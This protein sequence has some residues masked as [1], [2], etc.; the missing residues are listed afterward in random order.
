[1]AHRVAVVAGGSKGIGWA[2]S[3][4][5]FGAGYRVH[6]LSR[7]PPPSLIPHLPDKPAILHFPCDIT[8]SQTVSD[9]LST[10]PTPSVFVYSAGVLGHDSLLVSPSSTSHI[11]LVF[12]TNTLACIHTTRSVVRQMI[13]HKTPQASV[14]LIGS[15]VGIDG[16]Q[17]QCIYSASKSALVGFTKSLAK[18][19]GSRSI[20]VNM[21]A[22][23]F[24]ETD[25]TRG[26]SSRA[27]ILGKIPL[28]RFG[29]AEEVAELVKFLSC[30]ASSGYITGQV[31][32]VDGGLSL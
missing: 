9:I 20:R 13:K 23:G 7:S 17:G 15:I 21:V 16:N 22:P 19:V 27:E 5:L 28:E 8:Q 26:I 11:D 3:N 1:M 31:F 2:V 14:V 6:V 29:R 18:E 32:R 4:V 12:Q 10:I 30:S 24:I 25:M